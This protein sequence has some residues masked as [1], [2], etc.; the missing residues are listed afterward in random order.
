LRGSKAAKVRQ[1]GLDRNLHYGSL[2]GNKDYFL[3]LVL[4]H[5]LLNEYLLLTEEEYPI[6]RLTAKSHEILQDGIEVIM[7]VAEEPEKKSK[8]AEKKTS[9]GR[10]SSSSSTEILSYD[11]NL[12]EELR[13]LR[14]RLAAEQKIPPYIVF[15]DKA[16]K[17][18]ACIKPENREQ[19]LDISGVGAFKFEKYGEVFLK[20][21][22]KYK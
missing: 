3:R 17:E 7:K 15:N 12:F 14:R 5:L 6:L 1:Y 4:N 13:E 11:E 10:K 2:S 19:M 22:Q 8:K 21:I 18:M 16:L 20:S 9:T